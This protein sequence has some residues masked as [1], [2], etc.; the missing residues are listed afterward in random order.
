M[1]QTDLES[2]RKLWLLERPKYARFAT[3][4]LSCLQTQL[5]SRGIW[6]ELS[7]RAKEVDSLIRKLIKKPDHS[8]ESVGDKAGIRIVVR[9][10]HEIDVVLKIV[11]DLLESSSPDHKVNSLGTNQVGYLSAHVDAKFRGN[12]EFSCEFPADT[13]RAEIQVRTMAQHLWSDMA[14]DAIYKNDEALN[15]LPQKLVRRFHLLAGVV[16]LADDEFDRVRSEMPNIP[17]VNLLRAL[18]QHYFKLTSRRGDPEV[19]LDVI[20]LLMPLYEEDVQAIEGHLAE[21]Y[22]SHEDVLKAIYDQADN[23]ADRSAYFYQPEAL[24]IFDRLD[25]DVLGI[26]RVWNSR[27]PERELER[28]AN[29]FGVSFD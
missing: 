27:Y 5:R 26:R 9:Y 21:F 4:M 25:D 16:E 28:I 6:A 3:Q 8:Y 17:E 14:H 22:T 7:C 1:T 24:M 2:V 15:P 13:F 20:R 18:E 10:K 11:D 19:S 29:A 12:H 23:E